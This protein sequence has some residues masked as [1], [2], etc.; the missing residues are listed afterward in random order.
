MTM[1]EPHDTPELATTA[2][3]VHAIFNPSRDTDLTLLT[4]EE[5]AS[6]LRVGVPTVR[7]W[8]LKG[9]GPKGRLIGKHLRFQFGDVRRWVEDHPT[10]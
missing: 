5:V 7:K 9:T 6:Y 1:L 10:S 3:E 8:R 4:I 2:E